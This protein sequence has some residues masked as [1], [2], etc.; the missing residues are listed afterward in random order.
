MYIYIFLDILIS[1]KNAYSLML[2]FVVLTI[3]FLER[4]FSFLKFISLLTLK[5]FLCFYRFPQIIELKFHIS[6]SE[7]F[8]NISQ[9]VGKGWYF[10]L[11][12]CFFCS[13][14]SSIMIFCCPYVWKK[15]FYWILANK[16]H[17]AVW[18]LPLFHM[19]WG[20]FETVTGICIKC[21]SHFCQN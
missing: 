10:S 1:S 17:F 14:F 3:R 4:E 20:T 18:I 9:T 12:W 8:N 15:L 21:F 7:M 19:T 5:R 11:S 2:L 16:D 6:M 13:S